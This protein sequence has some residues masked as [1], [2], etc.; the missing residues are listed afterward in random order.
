MHT[1]AALAVG[2]VCAEKGII[3]FVS[4]DFVTFTDTENHQRLWAVDLN[5]GVS[6]TAV[7]VRRAHDFACSPRVPACLCACV[8]VCMCA[9]VHGRLKARSL[10]DMSASRADEKSRGYNTACFVYERDVCMCVMCSAAADTLV[11]VRR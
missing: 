4:V 1:H 6:D 7:S 11:H 3:G 2:R 9:C 5:I 8:H 10:H